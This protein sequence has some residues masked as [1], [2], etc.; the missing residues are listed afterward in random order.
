MDLY[1]AQ[2]RTCVEIDGGAH[3]DPTQRDHDAER[4][5]ALE[6]IGIRV[7]RIPAERVSRDA[8]DALL[9]PLLTNSGSAG[10]WIGRV[11]RLE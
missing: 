4:A 7:L 8:L 10:E 3:D 6:S 11:T 9:R 2:L 1:C 5:R